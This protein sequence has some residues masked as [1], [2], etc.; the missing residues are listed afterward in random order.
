L[1]AKG[2]FPVGTQDVSPWLR[3]LPRKLVACVGLSAF[4]FAA[5]APIACDVAEAAPPLPG[6]VQPGRDR[7]LPEPPAPPAQYDFSIEAPHRSPVPRDVDTIHFKLNDIHITGVVTLPP[8]GFRP[9]YQGLIG[10]DVT[11]SDIYNVAD[12]IERAYRQAGYPLVR[13]YVP[14]QR[15]SDGVFTIKVIEGY[16]AAISVEGG[17]AG[18]Q[19]T[20]K[21]YMQP[22]L[23]SKPLKLS[24]IERGLLLA[25]DLPGVT[26]TGVLRASAST[27]GASDLIVTVAQPAYSAGI[28]VDNRGSRF[29]GIWTV[30]G[31][32]AFNSI[33]ADADQLSASVTASPHSLEQIGGTLRYR[34]P[35]SD[36]GL[37]G[38]LLGV[39]THGEPGSTLHAFGFMTDSYAVG[40]RLSYPLIRSRLES[41]SL[42]GGF[43]VQDAKVDVHVSGTT[44]ISHDRWRVLDLDANYLNNDFLD[45]A[46]GMSVDV[47]QGLPIFG[48]TPDG[49][50]NLSQIGARTDFT[51]L[52]GGARFTRPL[53]DGF[54]V[55]FATQGQYSFDPLV[56]GEQVTFGGTQIGRGYDPGAI[57]GDRGIGGSVELRYDQRVSEPPLIS[58]QPY[59]FYDA[60]QTWYIHPSASLTDQS[61]ASAGG[62]VRFWLEDGATLGVELARTLHA[63]PGS[64]AGKTATKVLID[65]SIRF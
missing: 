24:V 2:G 10:K 30:T 23:D 17:D 22:V 3:K 8:D 7:P 18:T 58:L 14:P 16:V 64:D 29:S 31:D 27:P 5:A 36:D 20:I 54:S 53:D 51:K 19:A 43:T 1:A 38:S 42:D 62:G 44:P 39:V 55:S 34:L 40:P 13:A 11:L 46:L 50:P 35:L 63:V 32:V 45:G 33:L 4:M 61:I 28:A 65:A 15:V 52:A 47:A 59:V 6:A 60:A 21:G 37:V 41:L 26:A 49:S 9:L 25:N 48:A 12:G 57:T 56:S